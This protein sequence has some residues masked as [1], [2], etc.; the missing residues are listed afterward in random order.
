MTTEPAHSL[1]L[2]YADKPRW[3]KILLTNATK[4]PS[5]MQ[6]DARCLDP[7]FC[8]AFFDVC[9]GKALECPDEALDFAK[10]AL[11]LARRTDDPHL[12]NRAEGVI[13]HAH[14]SKEDWDKAEEAL[15]GYQDAAKDCCSACRSDYYRR[16]ADLLIETHQVGEAMDDLVRALDELG[17]ELDEDT[18]ARVRFLRGITHHFN[19]D[20]ERAMDDAG[21][22][23]LELSLDS[24]RGYFLDAVAFIACFL[25][26]GDKDDAQRA[27]DHVQRFKA[28]L[29]GLKEPRWVS[30]RTRISWVEGAAFAMLG[31]K[32]KAGDHLESVRKDLLATGP[33]KHA[34]AVSLDEMQLL[35][36]TPSE[37]NVRAQRRLVSVV[38]SKLK[39][40]QGLM[41]RFKKLEELLVSKPENAPRAIANLRR[42]VRAPVPGLV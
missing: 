24:P 5:V 32:R 42:A 6:R 23:L 4:K 3:W 21:K 10:A 1:D 16:R 22:A 12:L 15:D 34:A 31:D 39:L 36:R 29:N 38:L 8:Q 7:D 40:E 19:L 11:K 17:D 35:A 28:R 14:I 13:V 37:T 27:L 41:R 20:R 2:K 25:E 26:R 30:V 9:D 33:D 18:K